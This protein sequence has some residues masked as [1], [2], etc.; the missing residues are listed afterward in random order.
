MNAYA[1][2]PEVPFVTK[3]KL[4][5]TPASIENQKMVEY[6]DNHEFSFRVADG[7]QEVR[8]KVIKVDDI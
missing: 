6:I 8:D 2:K 7:V 1:V 3:R 5:R 4:A